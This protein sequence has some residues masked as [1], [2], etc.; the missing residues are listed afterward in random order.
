MLSD[1]QY[2][3]EAL[4]DQGIDY[5]LVGGH[6]F[7][8]QQ[9]VYDVLHLLRVIASRCDELS[10]AG[11][12]RSPFFSLADETIFWL[13]SRGRGLES[14]L[15][16]ERPPSELDE[17]ERAKVTAAAAILQFLRNNKEEMSVPQLLAEA[18]ERT[19]YDAALLAEFMGERKLG[20]VE[21]LV[22]QARAAAMGGVGS[23][24]EF[25]TQLSEYTTSAP[26][27]AL[28]TTSPETANIVR[29]MTIHQAKGLEFPVV[30]LPDI[31]RRMQTQVSSVE[32][33]RQLGPL[34]DTP[35]LCK[36]DATGLGLFRY[37]ERSEDAAEANR[38]FYV[39]CTRAADY[40]M[41]SSGVN[42]LG[43]PAG[44]WLKT[45][46]ESFDLASGEPTSTTTVGAQPQ[47]LANIV[48]PTAAPPFA[49][50]KR[51]NLL[52]LVEQAKREPT[53][54]QT[55]ALAA[56]L[57]V[58]PI[59]R[60]RFSVTRLSGQIIPAGGDWWQGEAAAVTENLDPLRF[61]TLVHAVLERVDFAIPDTIA[62]W[63]E[64]LA[65]QYHPIAANEAASAAGKLVADFI[66]SPR[67]A[68][69][70]AADEL[71][72]EVE[73]LMAWPPGATAKESRYLQG[74]LDCLYQGADG[75]WRVL[76]YKTNQ[77][78]AGEVSTL[79]AKYELQMLVYALAFEQNWG[80][81]PDELVLHFLRTGVENVTPWNDAARV[82][83]IEMVETALAGATT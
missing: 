6:A 75:R 54:Y 63:C 20:N 33:H 51:P 24:D 52:K 23:L 17:T 13:A 31:D 77:C 30:V 69:I 46:A 28:A 76:D 59:W 18:F 66:T 56:P 49:S 64:A 57:K 74:Y 39:A 68:E 83:A 41:L 70:R 67:A 44:P 40:L 50:A 26:K 55:E 48:A 27:E 29:L 15:F 37:L 25:V 9:E 47:V 8:S 14:G 38:L 2:Y 19:G 42:D 35:D 60:R 81:G 4:R 3:E 11:V 58:D 80:V 10:L 45:L 73:F 78:S 34:V 65:P 71:H 61:G 32:F 72:R 79:A 12:L 21:K 43:K 22:E 7:Y 16:A 5:Y 82:R 1:V 36:D 53:D 62:A